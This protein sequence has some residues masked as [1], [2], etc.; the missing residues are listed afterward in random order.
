MVVDRVVRGRRDSG[1]V[2]LRRYSFIMVA[3]VVLGLSAPAWGTSGGAGLGSQPKHKGAA[4]GAQDNPL[5]G[6]G[7][8]IWYVSQSN[9]GNL[10]SLVARA[11]RNGIATLMIKSG[12]GSSYWSQFSRHLIST[13]HANG[14]RVCAWQFVYGSQPGA[15]ARV[16]AG[17]VKTGADCLLIDAEGQ[18]E[19]KYV[20]AQTYIRDLR[21]QIGPNYP[22]AL[23]GFPYVDFHPAFPYSVFLGPGAAQYSAPQMYWR[24]IGTSVDGVYSHTFVY[25]RIY[26]RSIFPLGEAVADP[27]ASP[28]PPQQIRRFRQLSRA[29]GAGGV[30]WWLWQ[31][32]SGVAWHAISQTVGSLPGFTPNSS[33]ASLSQGAQGDLVVWAQEHL[34]SAGDRVAIDGAFGANTKAAVRRFQAA[35]GLPAIGRIGPATWR[36]LLRFAPAHVTWVTKRSKQVARTAGAGALLVPRSAGLPATRYE[37]PRNLGAGSSGRP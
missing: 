1:R 33:Y 27:P 9:G 34:V 14:L 24:D 35:R 30:S 7:M 12:D 5:A 6:R 19:G 16:G 3:L 25:N 15:E 26:G 2:G 23:A 13:L 10:A 8:W 18:Y 11:R 22:L 36:A 21:S 32:L 17:A 28:P 31:G 20:Q 29:Y 37:I 4:Q